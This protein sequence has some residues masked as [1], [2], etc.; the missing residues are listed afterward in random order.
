MYIFKYVYNIC[1]ESICRVGGKELS[2]VESTVRYCT[3]LQQ[4]VSF[5]AHQQCGILGAI[6]V[7]FSHKFHILLT[8]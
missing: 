8:I 3:N 7:F 6:K 5:L 2:T 1:I 4:K